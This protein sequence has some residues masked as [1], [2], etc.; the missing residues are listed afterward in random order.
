MR[1]QAL[2]DTPWAFGSNYAKEQA[3]SAADWAEWMSGKGACMF[4]LYDHAKM[5]GITGIVP[6]RDD[7]SGQ[8]GLMIA[9]YIVPQYRG[10][11]LSGLLYDARVNWAVEHSPWMKIVVS[12]RKSNKPSRRAN[13]KAG[14]VYTHTVK[15]KEWPDGTREDELSYEID[16]E[17]LR[18]N[19][20]SGT[21][22]GNY[23][24]K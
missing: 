19:K 2:Q 20:T 22:A 5:I 13:Q 17:D 6:K 24:T 9:S 7:P 8:S 10:Q 3:Y 16:L 4:G 14:A 18:Q 21:K 1:L 23:V 12:H 11:G 15:D